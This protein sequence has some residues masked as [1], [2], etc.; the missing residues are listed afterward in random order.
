MAMNEYFTLFRAP[1][2]EPNHQM[3]FISRT[4]LPFLCGVVASLTPL[5]GIQFID[6]QSIADGV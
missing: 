3:Q 6:I 5:Q 2:L 1:D 4:T